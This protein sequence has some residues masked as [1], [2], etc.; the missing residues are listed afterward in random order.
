MTKF[1]NCMVSILALCG[2]GVGF[3]PRPCHH[4]SVWDLPTTASVGSGLQTKEVNMGTGSVT[5]KVAAYMF[6]GAAS[7]TWGLLC[8]H[9]TTA[10]LFLFC[11][12]L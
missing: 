10:M 7:L 4:T 12:V 6:A 9:F 11:Q 3:E 1:T 2:R 8:P 5:Q